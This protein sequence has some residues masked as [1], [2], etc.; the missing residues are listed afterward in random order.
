MTPRP[1]VLLALSL[2]AA[3]GS[4]TM[5]PADE[6]GPSPEPA[7]SV[8][9]EPTPAPQPQPTPEEA[10][11]APA[12]PSGNIE[13][14]HLGQWSNTGIAESRRLVIRDNDAWASFWSQLGVGGRP[15]VDFKRNIVVAVAMGQRSSGGYDIAI[16]QVSEVAGELT[17]DV[18]ETSPAPTCATTMA[19]SQPADVVV[20]VGGA[21]ARSLNFREKKET[22]G[23]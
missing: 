1:L 10:S 20:V 18:V 2:V 11:P 17:V 12:P 8:P 9:V 15:E 19:L 5:R 23:C 14:R 21:G 13:V 6:P 7:P 3:C 4:G 22:R 16:Q